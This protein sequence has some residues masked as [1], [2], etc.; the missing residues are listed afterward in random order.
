MDFY[1]QRFRQSVILLLP[2]SYP[3]AADYIYLTNVFLEQ[4]PQLLRQAGT[5]RDCPDDWVRMGGLSVLLF[6]MYVLYLLPYKQTSKSHKGNRFYMSND[7]TIVAFCLNW[8]RCNYM[9]RRAHLSEILRMYYWYSICCLY[10]TQ[11]IC[12]LIYMTDSG[13][14]KNADGL[15]LP[16]A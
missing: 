13:V 9:V 14:H 8:M 4:Y 10:V 15:F 16:S 11:G 7:I 2:F 5:I 3:S 12:T 6:Q 1:G